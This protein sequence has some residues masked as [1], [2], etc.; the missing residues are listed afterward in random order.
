M[1]KQDLSSRRLM[2]IAL[3]VTVVTMLFILPGLTLWQT[4]GDFSEY[5][6]YEVLPGQFLYILAKLFGLYAI[7]LLWLQ[8]ML[9]LIGPPMTRAFDLRSTFPIHRTLGIATLLVIV[10]HVVLFVTAASIRNKIPA[11]DLLWPSFHDYYRSILTLGLFGTWLII[12]G[13]IAAFQRKRLQRL[14]RWGHRLSLPA[15]ALIFV[16][17]ILVGSESRVGAMPYFYV[18]ML[19]SLLAAV[20]FRYLLFHKTVRVS[21]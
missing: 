3:S 16:H 15:F 18:A 7:I 11:L 1:T 17:S 6:E 12:A 10:A 19:V 2:T 21:S 9:G 20:F 5:F 13:A 8:I 4:T 14:W